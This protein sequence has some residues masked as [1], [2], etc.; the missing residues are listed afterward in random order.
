MDHKVVIVGTWAG[1]P[2]NGPLAELGTGGTRTSVTTYGK[3]VVIQLTFMLDE[4]DDWK[5]WLVVVV[6]E[7]EV[8]GEG[9][10]AP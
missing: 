7:D 4:V 1:I 2:E 3:V 9:S 6:C 8:V 10:M 5:R